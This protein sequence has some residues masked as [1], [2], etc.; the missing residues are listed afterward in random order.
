MAAVT[1][2]CLKCHNDRDMFVNKGHDAGVLNVMRASHRASTAAEHT[3]PIFA[4]DEKGR[5]E[6]EIY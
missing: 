4:L 5:V 3:M 2:S 1:A 6:K